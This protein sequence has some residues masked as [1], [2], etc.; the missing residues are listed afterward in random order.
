MPTAAGGRGESPSPESG[1]LGIN[2]LGDEL[3]LAYDAARSV[4]E[5]QLMLYYGIGKYISMNS[6]EGF[7]G[8]G[9]I[10]AIS[11]RLE[12]ELPGLK[13][14]SARNLRNMRSFYEE[15]VTG[16]KTAVVTMGMRGSY[17]LEK[18]REHRQEAHAAQVVDALGAGDSFIAAFL[19][20]YHAN[21][22]DL[23]DAANE[24]SAYA[25]RC[26]GHYG[27]FGHAIA[28]E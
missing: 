1:L 20:R 28:E 11:E 3:N 23:A 10:D 27:A 15:W 17:L 13:G 7:W 21:G 5:K 25:A 12:K 2:P 18:G 4:N 9:A 6:R 26:C 19:A 14:F 24:G 22:G 8:K 16:A